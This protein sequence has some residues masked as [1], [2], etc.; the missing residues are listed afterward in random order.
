MQGFEG[1]KDIFRNYDAIFRYFEPTS[2][3][4]SPFDLHLTNSGD[5]FVIMDMHFKLG[6]HETQSSSAL[7]AI[8][9]MIAKDPKALLKG[10]PNHFLDEVKIR[11]YEPA[12]GIIGDP[13]KR[14]PTCRQS[15]DHS[16]VYIIATL[17]RKAFEKREQLL[18]LE[19]DANALEEAWKYLML[20]PNDY[21]LAAIHNQETRELMQKITFEHGGPEYDDLYPEGIPTSVELRTK[22]QTLESGI[23]KFPAG[24]ARNDQGILMP[25]V[26][27]KFKMLGKQAMENDE[28][29]RF[30]TDLENIQEM[31]N[32]DLESIYDCQLTF[33][34]NGIDE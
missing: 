18:A 3:N 12:F 16:M 8:I 5:D 11:A 22:D 15:A 32:A 20:L 28:L 30:V 31:S 7:H 21:T 17:L 19:G 14:D 24:H 26:R 27:H 23:V 1:P 4:E 6:L 34:E 2:G 25:L 33:A 13:A 29:V 9:E 10:E